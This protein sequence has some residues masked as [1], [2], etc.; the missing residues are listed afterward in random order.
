MMH[1]SL[2]SLG[3][4]FGFAPPEH[5]SRLTALRALKIAQRRLRPEV[6][7]KLL[8]VSSPRTNGSLAP[9]AW[10]FVFFDPATSGHSRM[11]TVAAKTS[12]EH[13][14]TVEAF[15]TAPHETVSGLHVI[16]QGKWLVDS[17]KALE[18]VRSES[19]LK[20]VRTVQYK[21]AQPRAGQ[22]PCWAIAFFGEAENPLAQFRVGAKTG[23]I[24]MLDVKSPAGV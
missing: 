13:P 14:D 23:T 10:R 19:K 16:P 2:L 22:E 4:V 15:S 21:L 7:A 20:G 24:E 3:C 6:R 9:V 5:Q 17:D 1:C 8:S 11:V 18:K 12:S